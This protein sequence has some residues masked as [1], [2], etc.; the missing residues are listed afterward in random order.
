[1]KAKEFLILGASALTLCWFSACSR[2]PAKQ[3]QGRLVRLAELEIDPAQCHYA[4][5]VLC[6]LAEYNERHH[7]VKGVVLETGG[8]QLKLGGYVDTRGQ[9][10]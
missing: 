6:R 7:D 2:A 4:S 8:F 1:M 3:A 10:L 5:G 9:Y